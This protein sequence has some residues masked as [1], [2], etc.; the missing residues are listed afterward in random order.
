M[1]YHSK[2]Y[3]RFATLSPELYKATTLLNITPYSV[4]GCRKVATLLEYNIFLKN[5]E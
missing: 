3:N 4:V 1:N 5:T 2:T